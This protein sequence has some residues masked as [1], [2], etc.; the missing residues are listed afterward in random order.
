MAATGKSQI[1]E[2]VRYQRA[3]RM[4]RPTS[5]VRSTNRLRP[6][7]LCS[8]RNRGQ[9]RQC[10]RLLPKSPI[11]LEAKCEANHEAIGEEGC[12][13]NLSSDRHGTHSHRIPIRVQYYE[14]DGQGRVHNSQYLNYFER[15]RVEMLRSI[16]ISYRELEQTGLMLVVR[17]LQ[18]DFRMPA[19]FDD[20]LELITSLKH[21]HGARIEHQYT[22]H[23]KGSQESTP[24]I[25]VTGHSVIACIDRD[26]KVRRL[27]KEMQ[28]L[29]SE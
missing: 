21:S 6:Q 14:T 15:G 5:L 19:Q 8:N 28:L 3:R 24:V 13:M 26:G 9:T 11:Y 16:G 4:P 23:K 27:P 2:D 20:E 18:V 29:K 7:S 17:S 1:A 25:I 10:D 22:L 12:V